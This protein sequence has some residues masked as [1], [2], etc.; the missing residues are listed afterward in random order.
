MYDK[1]DVRS[2]LTK[3]S[4]AAPK[5]P[6]ATEFAGADHAR[7]YEE[8]PQE[9]GP[10]GK[11]WYARGQ[12][13]VI[14]YSETEPGARF[15]RE[16]QLDEYVLILPDDET[17]ATVTAG[18]QTE[19]VP[20]YSLVIVPPGDSAVEIPA[21]GRIVRLFTSENAD[22]AAKCSNAE[23]Y[24]RRHPNIPPFERWPDPPGGFKI[25]QYSLDVPKQEGR[26]GR[27]FRCTTFMVNYIDPQFGPRDI[28]KLSPHFHDDFE[29][30]SLA[31]AGAYMH[32]LRW[33]WTIDMNTWREDEH[34]YCKA[35]SITVI[36]PPSI[37]T[38]RG[39]DPDLNQLVDIFSPPR[40]DF[41]KQ[42]GWVLNADDYPVPPEH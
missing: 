20:G 3:D 12:N 25:R 29:Q 10:Q 38:S 18:S 17:G 6:A 35:P 7:F 30:C 13:F 4:A 31:L 36:P 15:S 26:F 41:S 1:G 24:A 42:P 39:V 16:N 27:I 33:P 14:A 2:A 9:T 23:S 32:H 40:I 5:A 28:T 22:L 8:P 37:H 19:T 34:A 11:T 21:G